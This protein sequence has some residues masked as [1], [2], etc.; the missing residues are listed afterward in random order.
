MHQ[1]IVGQ[2]TK[3]QFEMIDTYPDV[4]CGCIGGGSNFAGFSFPFMMDK[5][6]GKKNSEF[7]ASEAKACPHTTRGAFT[8]DFGDTA[9]MT[10]LVKMYTLGHEYSCPPIHAGGLRYHAMA[11][12]I[13]H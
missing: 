4:F 10:P 8:Y 5:L 7:I 2:E 9:G 3:K 13:S 6:Q 12:L 1:T 11:P